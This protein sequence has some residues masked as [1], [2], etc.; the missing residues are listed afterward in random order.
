MQIRTCLACC[1]KGGGG[2]LKQIHLLIMLM[3][4]KEGR[5]SM[6]VFMAYKNFTFKEAVSGHLRPDAGMFSA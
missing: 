2:K 4:I 3:Q 5:K 1:N 6:I